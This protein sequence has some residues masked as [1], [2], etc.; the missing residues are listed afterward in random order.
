VKSTLGVKFGVER[1]GGG[2]EFTPIGLK[3][4]VISPNRRG[5]ETLHTTERDVKND[6]IIRSFHRRDVKMIIISP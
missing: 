4:E 2:V 6:N 5:Y 1:R 3:K